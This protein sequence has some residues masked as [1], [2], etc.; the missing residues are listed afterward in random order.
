MRR[1]NADNQ[2]VDAKKPRSVM[3]GWGHHFTRLQR[4]PEGQ[5]RASAPGVT[6]HIAPFFHCVVIDDSVRVAI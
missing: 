5:D 6:L 3:T 1:R 4:C 2:P